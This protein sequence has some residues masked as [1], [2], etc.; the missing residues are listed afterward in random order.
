MIIHIFSGKEND[1]WVIKDT[2]KSRSNVIYV[3]MYFVERH[4]VFYSGFLFEKTVCNQSFL[5]LMEME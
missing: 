1:N 5:D 2:T 3:I 4:A